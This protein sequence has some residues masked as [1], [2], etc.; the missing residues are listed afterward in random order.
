MMA[1]VAKGD[2]LKP[3]ELQKV[4]DSECGTR[5]IPDVSPAHK[6]KVVH[7][8]MCI[9][10]SLSKC[11]YALNVTTGIEEVDAVVCSLG[12]STKD[13]QVDS[14]VRKRERCLSDYCLL[15]LRRPLCAL[16]LVWFSA[17]PQ[18]C[19]N[20]LKT[21]TVGKNLSRDAPNAHNPVHTQGN[22][23]MIQAAMKKGVK[24]FVFVTSLGCGSSKDSIGEQVCGR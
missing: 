3:D 7:A 17:L 8:S 11:T 12:G 2:A 24:K 1:I 5:F 15:L 19:N 10:S 18:G 23:N 14:Q 9:F 16:C 20:N 22:I 4:M 13:P 21:L 6:E